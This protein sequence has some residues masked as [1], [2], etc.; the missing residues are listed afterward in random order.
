MQPAPQPT[1]E[2]DDA[3]AAEACRVALDLLH[4]GQGDPQALIEP[5]LRA[6]PDFVAAHCLRAARPGDG[7]P[8]RRAA[9][10]WPTPCTTARSA[11][12]ARRRARARASGRR[13]GLAGQGHE[14]LA[15]PVRRDR[16]ARPEGHA[17]VARGAFR[18][19][20]VGPHGHAARAHRRRAAPLARRRTRLRP[21]AG[22]V[23]LR[24]GR[25]RRPGAGRRGRARGPALRAAPG[26]AVHAVAHA[27]EMQGRSADGAAWLEG[28]RGIWCAQPGFRRAPV[29]ARSAVPPRPGRSGRRA[30]HPRSSG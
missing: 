19:S 13:A 14:T 20:A 10:T 6:R 25:G 30:A 18:R 29:V 28:T 1:T 22:D 9:G 7:Q 12:R 11:R 24:A 23:R 4:A 26:G 27:L 17:G 2:F 8:R 5:V 16:R 21:C 15:A 3:A